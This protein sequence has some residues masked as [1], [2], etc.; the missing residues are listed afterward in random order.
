MG[1][2]RATTDL[3][4]SERLDIAFAIVHRDRGLVGSLSLERREKSAFISYWIG[5]DHRGLGIAR[6]VIRLVCT[7]A[8]A[9][10]SVETLFAAVFRRN[11]ASLRALR[12]VG[13]RALPI[14]GET[15]GEAV[16]FLCWPAADGAPCA[17]RDAEI[18]AELERLLD[19]IDADFVFEAPTRRLHA[20]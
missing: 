2:G 17:A 8:S 12:C 9:K 5:R 1:G 19:A 16:E 15:R 11:E 14:R 6:T 18:C 20:P 4:T 7:R 10:L 3:V 13:W